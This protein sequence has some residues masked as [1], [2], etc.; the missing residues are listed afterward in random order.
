MFEYLGDSMLVRFLNDQI[1][2]LLIDGDAATDKSTDAHELEI[3]GIVLS[4]SKQLCDLTFSLSVLKNCNLSKMNCTSSTLTTLN[5][6]V[7]SFDDCLYLLD[8]RFECL[9]TMIIEI[10]AVVEPLS[11]REN[12]VSEGSKSFL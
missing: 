4:V 12:K 7:D 9:S 2:Q 3:F 11:N 8:G 5:V 1:T 10:T 6:S